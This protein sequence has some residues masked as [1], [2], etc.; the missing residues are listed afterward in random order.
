MVSVHDVWRCQLETHLAG[1]YALDLLNGL[2]LACSVGIPYSGCILKKWANKGFVRSFLCLL[3][4]NLEVVLEEAER[5]VGF[6]CSRA[7]AGSPPQVILDGDSQVLRCADV[8]KDLSMGLIHWDDLLLLACGT[9]CRAFLWVE[10]HEPL[11]LPGGEGVQVFL[12]RALVF[13]LFD[14]FAAHGVV[15][16]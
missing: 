8:L 15:S 10:V 11:F 7:D 2:D 6:A 4:A 3:V 1:S 16:E 13:C 5:L 12:Q 9:Q 14:G